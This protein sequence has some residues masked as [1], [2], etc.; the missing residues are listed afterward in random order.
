MIKKV[1]WWLSKVR[2]REDGLALPA[3]LAMLAVGSLLIVPSLNY[4]ATNL[5]ASEKV[6]EHLKGVLAAEAGIEDALWRVKNDTPTSFPYSYQISDINGMTVDVVIEEVSSISGEEVN[7][8][9][10]HVDWLILTK[11]V[12]Y[13]SGIYNY[14]FS[15][16]NNGSGNVKVEKILIDFPPELDYEAGSTGGNITADDPPPN[17]SPITGITLIWEMSPPLPA[18]PEGE[19][20]D[21]TFRLSGP[22]G[23]AG[24]EGHA[25]VQASR[26]DVSTVSDADSHP[27]WITAQAKDTSGT[28]VASIRAGVWKGDELDIS[29]WKIN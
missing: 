24:V 27:F 4:V 5:K 15:I 23:M 6:E 28:V 3:V 11:V 20:R 21:H 29:G 22:P 12:T 1:R 10:G 25:F 8:P 7:P 9:A 2:G 13:D 17:G 16:N 19:T 18:I 14:T 26:G